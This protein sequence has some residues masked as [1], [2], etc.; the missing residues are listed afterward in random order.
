[1]LVKYQKGCLIYLRFI[2]NSIFKLPSVGAIFIKRIWFL[3]LYLLRQSSLNKYVIN[4]DNQHQIHYLS[5]K[6]ALIRDK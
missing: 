1:M 3:M 5:Q 2:V 4:T 6:R